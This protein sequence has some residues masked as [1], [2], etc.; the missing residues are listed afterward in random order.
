MNQDD[1]YQDRPP[2]EQVSWKLCSNIYHNDTWNSA[3]P[4]ARVYICQYNVGVVGVVIEWQ[5]CSNV[6][7]RFAIYT[8]LVNEGEL[9]SK[10]WC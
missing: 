2:S 6:Q 7:T 10:A 8:S 9:S 4:S 3:T 5:Q 1:D